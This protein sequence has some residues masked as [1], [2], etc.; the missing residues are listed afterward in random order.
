M[1]EL[2]KNTQDIFRVTAY[3]TGMNRE[4]W[5]QKYPA[6]MGYVNRNTGFRTKETS[7]SFISLVCGTYLEHHV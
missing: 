2:V 3:L 4:T 5:L 7:V 6:N 1:K